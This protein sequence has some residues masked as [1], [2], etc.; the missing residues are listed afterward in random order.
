MTCDTD[1]EWEVYTPQG[2]MIPFKRDTGLCKG[3]TYIHMREHKEAVAMI[4][5]VRSIFEGFTK[6]QVKKVKLAR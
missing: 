6:N 2:T 1:T 5:T 3:M 4:E